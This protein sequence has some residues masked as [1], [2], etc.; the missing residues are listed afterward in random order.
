ML[1]CIFWRAVPWPPSLA[2]GKKR[3]VLQ[4][5][6]ASLSQYAEEWD[7][8]RGKK[9]AGLSVRVRVCVRVCVCAV[10]SILLLWP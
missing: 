8:I 9:R 4:D 1:R 6:I 3:K 5:R 2:P 7:E 10:L